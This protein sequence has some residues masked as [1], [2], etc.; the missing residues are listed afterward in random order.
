M[1]RFI[2]M[3]LTCALCL[4]VL[5]GNAFA[6]SPSGS[7][8]KN[9]TWILDQ[10]TGVLTISGQGDMYD[11]ETGY[12]DSKNHAFTNTAPWWAYRREIIAVVVEEGV[13]SI[14]NKAFCGDV[15]DE[16]Y[17]FCISRLKLAD[18]VASIGEFAFQCCSLQSVQLGSG[19]KTIGECA[20]WSNYRLTSVSLPEGLISVG[21]WAF[22]WT[23]MTEVVIPRSVTYIGDGAFGI[24]AS[25][26]GGPVAAVGFTISG[27]EG[28]AA[29]AYYNELL[30]EYNE[31]KAR[32]GS[33]D[34]MAYNYPSDG[35]VYFKAIKPAAVNVTVNGAAVSWTDAVPFID[36]NSRTMVPLRAVAEALG[37]TVSWDGASREAIFTDGTKT[38]YFPVGS[39]TARTG[40][41]GI[42]QMDTVA[43]IV[44]DRTFAPVRYLAEF[45]GFTVGWDSA[46]RTVLIMT[47]AGAGWNAAYREFVLDMEF[48]WAGQEYAE[49]ATYWDATPMYYVSLYD[50]DGDTVPELMIT[51]GETGRVSRWAYIYSYDGS[52][53]VYLGIGPTDAFYDPA[54]PR[55]IYGYF[56]I[57]GDDIN[58]TLYE[59][60]GWSIVT[61]D[62]GEFTTA[63]WPENLLLLYGTDV[64]NLRAMG[65]NQFVCMSGY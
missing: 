22:T 43:V 5:C 15:V 46:A 41:G 32:F 9:L 44:N 53:V 55:G 28:S 59:K 16:E 1:K 6:A 62:M 27:Y 33:W 42:V 57:M 31:D 35:T 14:G 3:L 65:W 39:S 10:S 24:N 64:E 47:S 4:A 12:D 51:N 56:H 7:C 17:T 2:C 45:F 25:C 18:S 30:R 36:E 23:A 52:S 20:F 48:L 13:T 8:G 37:L 40:N 54:Q 34:F 29:E 63:T 11:Y 60:D 19:L 21:D 58:C 50:M 26:S 49:A 38:I 61:T